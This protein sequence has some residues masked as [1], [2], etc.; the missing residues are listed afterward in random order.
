MTGRA[1]E[2]VVNGGGDASAVA[3]I[4]ILLPETDVVALG[5]RIVVTEKKLQA[6]RPGKRPAFY[7]PI[8]NCIVCSPGNKRKIVIVR[9]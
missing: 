4:K 2:R 9:R 5:R 7:I 8:P 3:G 6:L 1:V